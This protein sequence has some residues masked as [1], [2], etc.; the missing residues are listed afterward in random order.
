MSNNKTDPF[1][2][3]VQSLLDF[4]TGHCGMPR[5][6]AQSCLKAFLI[7]KTGDQR[8]LESAAQKVSDLAELLK[9][10]LRDFAKSW[11]SQR[12]LPSEVTSRDG[13]GFPNKTAWT[14][15]RM[16]GAPEGEIRLQ[17]LETLLRKYLP[18]LRTYLLVRFKGKPG[19]TQEWIDDCLQAF[20]NEKVLQRELIRT[21]DQERGRFR[22]LLKTS[23]YR[24]AISLLRKEPPPQE[25]LPGD[26]EPLTLTSPPRSEA[27]LADIK[28]ARGVLVDALQR[29]LT[30][31]ARKGQHVT[32]AVFERR[33]VLPTLQSQKPE[34][35]EETAAFLEKAFGEKLSIKAVSNQQTQGERKL[36]RSIDDV[37]SQYCRDAAEIEGERQNLMHILKQDLTQGGGPELEKE[38]Q[39]LM[40]TLCQGQPR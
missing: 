5:E 22:D 38:L 24:F 31:C 13:L 9:S 29:M 28:W 15:V 30:E 10:S 17:A 18:A 23:I 3:Y 12:Q 6:S 20:I 33:C 2:E 21:A 39:R 27:A 16:A 32:K 40:E 11:L 34:S 25:P 36:R 19:I 26:D 7:A 37:L 4:L 14:M 1:E 8:F 35:L